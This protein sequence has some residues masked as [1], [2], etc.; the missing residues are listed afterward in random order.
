MAYIFT[1]ITGSDTVGQAFT[2]VNQNLQEV[3]N[4]QGSTTGDYLPLSGGSLDAFASIVIPDDS[5][6]YS[7]YKYNGWSYYNN[8][9]QVQLDFNYELGLDNGSITF[10]NPAS[11]GYAVIVS[12]PSGEGGKNIKVND[13]GTGWE[14]FELPT[15][16]LPL[17]GGTLTGGLSGTTVSLSNG[18]F[19][20][21][22]SSATLSTGRTI[23]LPNESGTIALD[24]KYIYNTGDTITGT[25]TINDG[26]VDGSKI[27][28]YGV[29]PI[30]YLEGDSPV[31]RLLSTD[32]DTKSQLYSSQLIFDNNGV[33]SLNSAVV[34]SPLLTTTGTSSITLRKLTGNTG[35]EFVV[36][37]S[38]TG[39]E[40]KLVRVNNNAT[41]FN[42]A[43]FSGSGSVSVSSSVD[44][45]TIVGS[46]A[47]RVSSA[48]TGTIN[49]I[50]SIT[51]NT[52]VY[53]TIAA[54]TGVNVTESNGTITIAGN[55]SQG[56][57]FNSLGNTFANTTTVETSVIF[58]SV[59]GGTTLSASTA[60][61]S[62]QQTG[63]RR[64]RFTANGTIQ[65]A[66][67]AG[68][69]IARMKLGSVLLASSTTAVHNSIPAN[70]NFF[71][72][73]TFTVRQAGASGTVQ[74][75][76]IMHNTH[77]NFVANG[78][79]SAPI[80]PV[81]TTSFNTTTDKVFDFT[82]QWGTSNAS[83]AWVI[84]EATLE[85]LDI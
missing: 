57:L 62:P 31:V 19:Y 11:N 2:K 53:R 63:G 40:G 51:N 55:P 65:S 17:S 59:R 46:G 16:Y 61:I 10:I 77:T 52:L 5:A 56:T 50:S 13:S 76:G 83:N 1:A 8:D 45:Y 37:P 68:N 49:V 78:S 7:D 42:F 33:G 69:L 15:N 73:A 14:Y 23:L 67:S 54:G 12:T 41:G 84:N 34:I 81:T 22:L 74:A 72:E 71:I 29:A 39:Q 18:S 60:T 32:T 21:T 20:N 38:I 36:V 70:T 58:S 27:E 85:Y 30:M 3:E 66:A 6:L 26:L 48:G 4:N 25:Y 79:N 24:G 44:G 43:S 82:L 9:D 28:M 47:T 35:G 75:R 80:G 64:Y